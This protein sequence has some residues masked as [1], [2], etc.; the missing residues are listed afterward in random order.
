MEEWEFSAEMRMWALDWEP[1]ERR[2][3]GSI[4]R[5]PAAPAPMDAQ[6]AAQRIAMLEATVTQ[7]ARDV[8][9]LAGFLE[10]YCDNDGRAVQRTSRPNRAAAT[11]LRYQVK[12]LIPQPEDEDSR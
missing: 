3:F 12:D 6:E 8:A 9:H 5:P 7:L 10:R 1:E 4:D 11:E 2:E